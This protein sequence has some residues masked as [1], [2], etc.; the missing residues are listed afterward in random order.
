M[1]ERLRKNLDYATPLPMRTDFR[2]MYVWYSLTNLHAG[3]NQLWTWNLIKY[4]CTS[5]LVKNQAV[6][7]RTPILKSN[8]YVHETHSVKYDE[9]Q[10]VSNAKRHFA[11]PSA[12]DRGRCGEDETAFL[13]HSSFC[14]ALSVQGTYRG[15]GVHR[16]NS[17]LV[18]RG[19]SGTDIP[20]IM[21]PEVLGL[22]LST[23][24]DRQSRLETFPHWGCCCCC[25]CVCT[26]GWGWWS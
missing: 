25:C 21:P 3:K 23:I 26:D 16:T 14:T 20:V 5:P 1:I 10:V 13:R 11:W 22:M 19:R 24:K 2:Y 9:C 7:T 17:S 4:C 12:K 6:M 8:S 15:R 18:Y